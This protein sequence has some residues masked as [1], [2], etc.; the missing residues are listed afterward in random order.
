MGTEAFCSLCRQPMATFVFGLPFSGRKPPADSTIGDGGN[1]VF[2]SLIGSLPRK[3]L[4]KMGTE[5]FCSLC[6]Q[7]MAT[8]VSGLP[9]NGRKSPADS[10]IGDG[11]N[12]VFASLIGSLPRKSLGS[13]RS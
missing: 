13:S 2:A 1:C 7:P 4:G 11:G 8:S 9:F 3:S 12:C 10:T 5:A 6:R